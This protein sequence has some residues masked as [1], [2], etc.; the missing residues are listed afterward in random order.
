MLRNSTDLKLNMYNPSISINKLV[1]N[2]FLTAVPLLTQTHY[3]RDN[4]MKH[5]K[6]RKKKRIKKT[7][8]KKR[9][10]E[11]RVPRQF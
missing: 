10:K 7:K 2:I 9:K 4:N 3:K 6:L 8:E 11:D 5:D 1:P